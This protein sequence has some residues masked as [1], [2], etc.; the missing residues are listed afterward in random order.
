MAANTKD[1]RRLTLTVDEAARLLGLSRA[2]TYRA[3]NGGLIPA[4]EIGRRKLIPRE[5]FLRMFNGNENEGEAA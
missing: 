3:V 4:I 2:A 1:Q 5:R